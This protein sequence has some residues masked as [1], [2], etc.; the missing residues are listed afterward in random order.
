M[1][2]PASK[3]QGMN[4]QF[5]EESEH[6]LKQLEDQLSILSREFGFRQQSPL[7][8]PNIIRYIIMILLGGSFKRHY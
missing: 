4:K 1:L 3:I 7:G 6:L 8:L 2:F 5:Q